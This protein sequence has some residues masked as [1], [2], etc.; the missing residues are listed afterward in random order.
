M[1]FKCQMLSEETQS[2]KLTH[3]IS[4]YMMFQK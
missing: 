4:I 1:T 3:Y 2:V